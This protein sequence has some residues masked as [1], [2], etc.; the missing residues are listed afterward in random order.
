MFEL[1]FLLSIVLIVSSQ[2]LPLQQTEAAKKTCR[3]RKKT[4]SEKTISSKTKPHQNKSGGAAKEQMS[5]R[6]TL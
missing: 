2:F 4:H 5:F 6:F 1:L 3:N